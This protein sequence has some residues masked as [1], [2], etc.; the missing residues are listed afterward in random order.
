MGKLA[1]P[2]HNRSATI[3]ANTKM[4]AAIITGPR[5]LEIRSLPVPR[6]GPGQVRVSLEGCGVCASDLPVWQGRAYFHYPFEPGAPGHEAWGWVDAVGSHVTGLHPG[7]RVA[8]LS[9]HAYAEYDVVSADDV[10]ILPKE[11]AGRPVPA[12]PLACAVNAFR[13]TQVAAG[14]TVAIVGIGFLGALLTCLAART[15]ATV[16]AISRRPFALDVAR[17]CGAR[18]AIEMKDHWAIV[19]DVKKLTEG[20]GCEV[21]IEAVG[22]QWPLDLAADLTAVRGRL[23]IA[24]YHQ[25]G[26]RQINVQNWNWKGLDV[27]NAHERDPRVCVR[28]MEEAVRAAACGVLPVQELLTHHYTLGELPLAMRDMEERPDG[29]LKGWVRYV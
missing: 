12:E 8:L 26:P 9:F 28:G 3:C 19:E 23:V 21:V 13:R 10:V 16:I 1:P 29:F 22:A 2:V 4:A 20:R 14:S 18:H 25:D 15:Q 6:P 11:L 24:G 17:R 27:I 7:D 5:A